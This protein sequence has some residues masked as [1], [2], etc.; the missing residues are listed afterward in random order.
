ME[1]GIITG[2]TFK[3]GVP[4]CSVQGIRV[5]TE[6]PAVPVARMHRGMFVVPEQGQKVQMLSVGDQ[7]FIVGMLAKNDDAATPSLAPGDF[8]VQL[9]SGTKLTFIKNANDNYDVDIEASGNV[10][11]DGIDFDAHVHSN[12]EGGTT[13]PPQ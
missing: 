10:T 6:Y 13:G 12:P 1:N 4:V 3:E 7:R 5:D 2:V 8:A 9:D 11:I